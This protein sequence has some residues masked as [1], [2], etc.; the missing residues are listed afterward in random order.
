MAVYEWSTP[1]NTTEITVTRALDGSWRV[2]V[3]GGA[4]GGKVD[5]SIVWTKLGYFQCEPVKRKECVNIAEPDDRIPAEQDPLVQHPFTDW[6]DILLDRR[7]PLS[8]TFADTADDDDGRCFLLERNSVSVDAPIP[9]TGY[10]LRDDGT[11]TSVTSSF[12]DL[13]LVGELMPAPERA[14]LP[15]EITD[16][17][18]L[19]TSPPPTKSPSPSPSKTP[20]DD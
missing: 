4:H 8:V 18:P 3:P 6:L 16:T 15:G 13:T 14:Q 1:K 20:K 9:E 2:D 12:G 7:N 19:S 17:E 5:I 11:I 10:C